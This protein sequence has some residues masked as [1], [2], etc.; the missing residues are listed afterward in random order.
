MI[1]GAFGVGQIVGPVFAGFVS[2]RLNS[3]TLP[4][5]AAAAALLVAAV[6]AVL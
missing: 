5:A 3:F 4:S 6:L 1:T 2:D